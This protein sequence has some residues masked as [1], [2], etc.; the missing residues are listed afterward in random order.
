MRDPV[1]VANVTPG[2]AAAKKPIDVG[3][4]LLFVNGKHVD[5]FENYR[6]LLETLRTT[7]PIEIVF[8][9]PSHTS[10]SQ[11]SESSPSPTKVRLN[12]LKEEQGKLAR[13]AQ[14]SDGVRVSDAGIATA[15]AAAAV[16]ALRAAQAALS[17]GA[18]SPDEFEHIALVAAAAARVDQE[19]SDA[20]GSG[21][22]HLTNEEVAADDDLCRAH[23]DWSPSTR[24]DP[25]SPRR[26][27]FE[28]ASDGRRAAA[29][30]SPPS[31]AGAVSQSSP[32]A[33]GQQARDGEA[34]SQS[35]SPA[36]RAVIANYFDPTTREAEDTA[37]RRRWCTQLLEFMAGAGGKCA[38][39]DAEVRERHA[40]VAFQGG[41]A[42]CQ[43][44]ALLDALHLR[45]DAAPPGWEADLDAVPQAH[46]PLAAWNERQVMVVDGWLRAARENGRAKGA[47]E[48]AAAR[49]AAE[50]FDRAL[51]QLRAFYFVFKPDKLD[52]HGSPR[53]GAGVYA[54]GTSC[55]CAATVL[56]RHYGMRRLTPQLVDAYGSAPTGWEA[57]VAALPSVRAGASPPAGA[58]ARAPPETHVARQKHQ[59]ERLARMQSFRGDMRAYQEL[60]LENAIIRW[61]RAHPGGT[62]DE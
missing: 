35:P 17:R 6:K 49:A 61:H 43:F 20:A 40:A 37:R 46:G 34:A 48:T 22:R 29:A 8:Q 28:S 21:K 12:A 13:Q 45:F 26:L 18:L 54:A 58:R 53:R 5:G 9:G 3:F 39:E 31:A 16:P 41:V 42:D 23:I 15:A 60:M 1:L 51:A 59:D 24:P 14:A 19:H 27:Q 10:D 55:R 56:L 38:Q 7:R 2:S 52:R 36:K 47:V 33:R 50:Q 25:S 32:A 4:A 62:F 11:T 30:L 57:A 44:A